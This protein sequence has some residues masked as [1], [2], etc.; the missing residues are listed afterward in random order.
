[1]IQATEFE[2]KVT[3]CAFVN[4]N[5]QIGK[6]KFALYFE[7]S[8]SVLEQR[9]LK[10]GET[11]GRSDDNIE[12]IKKR[13]KTFVDQSKPVVDWYEK[14]GRLVKISS[15]HPVEEVYAEARKAFL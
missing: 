3:K 7:C 14:E 4:S 1:M 5:N 15:E 10:R 12:A 8:E 9:L 6:A 13:F 11:S 2:R